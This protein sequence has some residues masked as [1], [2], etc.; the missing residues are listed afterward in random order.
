MGRAI[1]LYPQSCMNQNPN[2]SPKSSP[3][4]HQISLFKDALSGPGSNLQRLEHTIMWLGELKAE[5][6]KAIPLLLPF[7]NSTTAP[8][9]A[10]A[11][12]ARAA[13][14]LIQIDE[15]QFG[16]KA[17]EVLFELVTS[18]DF[19]KHLAAVRMLSEPGILNEQ[20]TKRVQEAAQSES[21]PKHFKE[22]VTKI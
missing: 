1:Y 6:S 18:P 7:V 8:M 12:N 20:L 2:L 9:G 19:G 14:T 15:P 10:W 5:G 4:E 13:C 3:I 22:W 17:R 21:A 16:E 11:V